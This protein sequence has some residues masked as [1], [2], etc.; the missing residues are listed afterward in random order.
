MSKGGFEAC[1]AVICRKTNA[2][3][4]TKEPPRN[5]MSLRCKRDVD[6]LAVE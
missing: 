5:K 6:S 3:Y 2:V 4:S 1:S